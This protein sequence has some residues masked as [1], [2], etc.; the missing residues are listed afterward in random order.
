MVNSKKDGTAGDKTEAK[1]GAKKR[2]LKQGIAAIDSTASPPVA[3]PDPTDAVP[4]TPADTEII[5]GG[6]HD[7]LRDDFA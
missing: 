7:T 4:G 3:K 6:K 5:I 2:K 1:P